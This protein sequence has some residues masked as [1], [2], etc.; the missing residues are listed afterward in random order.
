MTTRWKPL[1][2]EFL[3]SARREFKVLLARRPRPEKWLFIVGCYNSGT[4]LL[5]QLLGM[6]PSITTLPNEGQYLTDQFV[7][8]YTIGLPRMWVEREDL[9]RLTEDDEGPDADRIKKEWAMRLTKKAPIILEKTP[10]N[11]AR[12][13]WLQKHFN[14][15]HFI[16][17]IRDPYAVAEGIRRKAR[18]VH[19]PEGW[20]IAMTARQWLRSNQVLREDAEALQR[21]TWIRYEDL[22][23]NPTETLNS[24]LTFLNLPRDTLEV[25]GKSFSVHDR[26]QTMS[27]L[28]AKS[29]ENLSAEEIDEITAIVM[30]FAK[31]FGYTPPQR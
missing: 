14:N 29:H 25:T 13:R 6:H 20:P 19:R 28:N 24:I 5:D 4:T 1:I 31:Q 17:L 30:P 22:T 2:E 9:F 16:G 11:A 12:T 27:N 7:V 26:E 3:R 18:P 21:F 10:A 23:E 15:A 8:D